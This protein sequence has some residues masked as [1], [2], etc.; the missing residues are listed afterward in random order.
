MI[1]EG[2]MCDPRRRADDPGPRNP[3]SLFR[4][5]SPRAKKCD[6]RQHRKSTS[7]DATR[8]IRSRDWTPCRSPPSPRVPRPPPLGSGARAEALDS[9]RPSPS[10]RARAS[11]RAP[12]AFG[13]P[14]NPPPPTQPLS[15]QRLAS[16][17][18]P[19]AAASPSRPPAR[20][21]PDS[22]RAPLRCSP[23]TT[24]VTSPA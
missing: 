20:F 19:R 8:H 24:S 4:T 13:T 12:V 22:S 1:R 9:V 11:S 5:N 6:A 18:I 3:S 15:E 7:I 17:P 2:S 16:S 14:A 10:R 23:S 21:S